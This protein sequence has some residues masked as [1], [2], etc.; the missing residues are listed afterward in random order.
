MHV[1]RGVA[2]RAVHL[3][4]AA[5]RVRVL[6]LTQ[7]GMFRMRN[8]ECGMRNAF[9]ICYFRIPNSESETFRIPI[10]HSTRGCCLR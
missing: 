9:R 3:R 10:P 7:C 6:H 5:Q 1:G 2:S 8:V 4:H